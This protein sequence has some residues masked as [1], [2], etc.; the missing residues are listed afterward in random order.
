MEKKLPLHLQPIIF[1]SSDSSLSKGISKLEKEGKLKK[2]APRIYTSNFT[3]SPEEIISKNIL[4][5][6]G[7]QYPG[8]LL[9]HRSAFEYKPTRAGHI[10]IT[11]S[12][13]KKIKLPGVTLRILEGPGPI[14]GDNKFVAGLHASQRERALLEN[15]QVSRKP[16]P[17]SKTLSL[18]EIEA[19]L[20]KIITVNGEDEI[21]KVR[22]KAREI[23]E[24]LGMLSEFEKL[25]KLINAL[26]TTKSS[27]ILTSPIARARAFGIPYDDARVALFEKLFIALQKREFKNRPDRNST[28]T[29]F[30]NFAFFESYFS[31]YIE[32]TVFDIDEAKQI[33]ATQKP[34]PARD[35]DSHDVLGTYQIA[36]SREEMSITPKDANHFLEILQYRHAILL[37]ARESKNPGQFKNKNNLVGQTYFVDMTLTR[38]TL[39]KSFEFYNAITQPFAKA[40]YIMFVVTEV[41]PFLD[42]NGRVARIMMNT[43][44][45][46][47]RQSKIIIPTV[48]RDDYMG[49]LRKLTRQGDPD[50]YIRMLERA[51]EFSGWIYD[52]N[53]DEMQSYLGKCN[54]FLE[55]EAGKLQIIA[56]SN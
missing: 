35:E 30:R 6:I 19:Q 23:A 48:Y 7:N 4:T 33:I 56:R 3:D 49:A 2:I 38:G 36:S 44:L 8:S 9:S 53:M 51:H 47:G 46:T 27:K 26:L 20:E 14:P 52:E 41:H 22:D 45:T 15:L 42:G 5:I 55:P 32:G 11:Y 54:A 25:N 10:F 12:Y 24:Q 50:A 18:P 17:E 31:N 39:I 43:E 29:S 40:A 1:G 34:L 37:S 13:T 28:I 16:G 21:N